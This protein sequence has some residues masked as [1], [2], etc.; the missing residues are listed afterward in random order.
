MSAHRLLR[1]VAGLAAL[2]VLAGCG[3][4]GAYSLPLPGGA[5]H[6]KTYSVMAQFDDVQDLVPQNT[7]RVNDVAIGDVTGIN[8]GHDAK[9]RIVANVSMKINA[10][11]HLPRNAVAT[12]E[13]TTLLGEKYVAL[14]PPPPP[15][16]P[17]SQP[18]ANG[19][20]IQEAST[21]DLPSVEEVFGALSAVLNGGDLGDLQTI[22]VQV[23]KALSGREQQVRGA[24]HQLDVFVS[25]LN[26]QKSQ[27]VR[28]LNEL[29][30]F[31]GELAQQNGTIATALDDIGPGLKVLADERA[32]FTSLLT[33]LSRFGRVATHV[34]QA[35][36]ASTVADLR[37]LQPV[38]GHLAAAG[39]NLPHALEILLTF[40]FPKGFTQS[41][42]GDYAG[43]K[44]TFD[45]DPV[46]CAILTV[47]NVN[48]PTC[49]NMSSQGALV[50]PKSGKKGNG[51]PSLKPPSIKPTTKDPLGIVK[52]IL[53]SPK[54]SGGN[55]GGLGGLLGGLG[56]SG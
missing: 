30:R 49:P 15:T 21:S 36:R 9:G 28:A 40:P 26:S 35:S 37:D 50:S 7:V 32:Q 52:K 22:N 3:F 42:P 18:L 47:V 31:S 54:S 55:G 46:F 16:Q 11:V 43:L 27:I 44:L 17:S 33:K 25:G 38:L 56:G 45:A 1:A 8:V 24:L 48:L 39:S 23:S 34:I 41:A 19:D 12:L 6:G 20:Q 14:S 10:S 51:L 53:P 29:N 13:Q 5:A 4:K 2:M